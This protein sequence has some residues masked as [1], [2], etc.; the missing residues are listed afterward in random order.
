M[1]KNAELRCIRAMEQPQ[2]LQPS[3]HM[4]CL[5]NALADDR[6]IA[7]QLKSHPS[8]KVEAYK[9]AQQDIRRQDENLVRS[10]LGLPNEPVKSYFLQKHTQQQIESVSIWL[11]KHNGWNPPQL[12]GTFDCDPVTVDGML[13]S[14][15]TE[16]PRSFLKA[17]NHRW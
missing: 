12:T 13:L 11:L 6:H 7:P 14:T 9:S 1:R 8:P 17:L 10:L 3:E 2:S 4:H 5:Y 15:E 16:H